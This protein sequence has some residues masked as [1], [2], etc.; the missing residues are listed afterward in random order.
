[1]SPF[2]ALTI[3]ISGSRPYA[4]HTARLYRESAASLSSPL[5]YL[6]TAD[7]LPR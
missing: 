4:N 7:F 3:A 6:K 2:I 5:T 1:M